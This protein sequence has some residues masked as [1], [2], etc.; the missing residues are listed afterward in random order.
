MG[1]CL[2]WFAVKGKSPEVVRAEL[3]VRCTGEHV[4]YPAPRIAGADLPNGWYLVQC[5]GYECQ[6]DGVYTR[7]SAGCEVISLFVEEHVM[8][9]RVSR[10]K[11]GKRLWSVVYDSVKGDEHLEADGDVPSDFVVN[12][13]KVRAKADAGVGDYFDI[14]CRLATTLTGYRYDAPAKERVIS[15]FEVLTR[16]S[17]LRRLFG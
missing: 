11:D 13:D 12:R 7:L 3:G 8:V 9:S 15:S 6:E 2:T 14:P 5:S 16:L 10:W 1:Y 17:W 4:S